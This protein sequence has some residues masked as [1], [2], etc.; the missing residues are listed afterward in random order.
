MT[1][2]QWPQKVGIDLL[3]VKGVRDGGGTFATVAMSLLCTY[4]FFFCSPTHSSSLLLAKM[5][6]RINAA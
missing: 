5:P 4:A 6:V 2:I 3:V 1:Q